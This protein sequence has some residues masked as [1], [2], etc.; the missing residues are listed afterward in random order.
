MPICYIRIKILAF[1][2]IEKFKSRNP[3]ALYVYENTKNRLEVP[4]KS[5]KNKNQPFMHF[6][7]PP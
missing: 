3:N 4:L 7:I 1:Y 5:R 6:K 2:T